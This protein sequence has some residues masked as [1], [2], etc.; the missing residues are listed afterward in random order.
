[1][2]RVQRIQRC[3]VSLMMQYG[4]CISV[5]WAYERQCALNVYCSLRYEVCSL[6]LCTMQSAM[7]TYKGEVYG[8][9]CMVYGVLCLVYAQTFK[10]DTD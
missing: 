3:T 6:E 1:M 8:V 4:V 7:C 9:W 2:H 5:L 10:P